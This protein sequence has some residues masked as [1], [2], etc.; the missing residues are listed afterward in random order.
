MIINKKIEESLRSQS[1]SKRKKPGLQ[2]S[3]QVLFKGVKEYPSRQVVQ[4]VSVNPTQVAQVT[5]H[6]IDKVEESF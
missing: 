4:F 5:W 3:E 1:P 2:P 6:A